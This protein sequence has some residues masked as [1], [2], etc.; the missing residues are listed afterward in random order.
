MTGGRCKVF[1]QSS[2]YE[3]LWLVPVVEAYDLVASS[4]VISAEQ[5]RRIQADLLRPAVACFKIDDFQRDA[6]IKDL[7]YRC[8]NFQAWHLSAVGLAGLA[9]KDESLV[10]YAINSPYGLRHLIAH[11]IRDDGLFWERSAGYHD[12]VI[13][14]LVPLA[15][16]LMHCGVDVY[17]MTVPNDRSRDEDA[18]YVTDTTG[19]PKSLRMMFEAPWYLAFPDLS[20]PALG[21]SGHGPLR[22]DWLRLVGY[23]RYRDPKLAW[24][25]KRDAPVFESDVRRG[26]VGFL[27]YYRYRYRYDDLR[28]DGQPIRWQHRDPTYTLSGT[29]VVAGD[30]G[31]GQPD[32]YL[33]NDADRGDF[34]LEWTMTRLA[35]V[36]PQDRAWVVY[37]TPAGHTECRKSFPLA[38]YCPERSR[39]YRFRLEV[40]GPRTVLLRDGKSVASTPTSHSHVPDWPWLIYD[41]PTQDVGKALPLAEGTFANSGRHRHGCS[42]FPSSGVAVLRQTDGDLTAKPDATAVSLSFGPHGGGHGHPDKLNIVLYA[43]GRQW[44]PDFGSMPYESHWKSQWTAH[45]V[46]HNTVV[47]DEVSQRPA[48]NRDSQWPTDNASHKVLGT[49]ERFDPDQK[50]A[51]A[52][53]TSAYEGMT[54][55]RAV[56]LCDHCVIDDFSVR[57]TALKSAP[58][59]R[60]IDYV[61]HIDGAFEQCSMPM[62]R[63]SGPLG[64]KCGYQHVRQVQAVST[65]DPLTFTFSAGDSRLRVWV[66]PLDATPTEA[67][68]ADG[69]TNQPDKTMPMLV[70]RRRSPATRFL[71]LLEP[72][73]GDDPVRSVRIEPGDGGTSSTLILERR[74]GRQAAIPPPLGLPGK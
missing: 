22:G 2:L 50:L 47:L 18:H 28:L 40:Q 45:T 52:A 33:L 32:L 14:A 23:H 4:G 74:S 46:S 63:R 17:G 64:K 35:D 8:Y 9:L 67:I 5:D 70:L 59:A 37:H 71:T 27:H 60:Q 31:A 53:C 19:A 38:G 7:H 30:G 48:G 15:E 12:F 39:P 73:K 69:L 61:L 62:T 16:A 57:P 6:R 29:S 68:L 49:L 66:V 34:A 13:S 44:I 55:R 58:P 65:G 72:V 43:Q 51:G 1:S 24:G 11:D 3:A 54:L 21:D 26:R 56:R 25:L 42:L 10:D 20:F 41:S 36:G